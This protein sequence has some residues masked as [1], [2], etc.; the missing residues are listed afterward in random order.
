MLKRT[1]TFASFRFVS[2]ESIIKLAVSMQISFSSLLQRIR[3]HGHCVCCAGW[4]GVPVTFLVS[5]DWTFQLAV[6]ETRLGVTVS[7]PSLHQVQVPGQCSKNGASV[8][9]F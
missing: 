1:F 6:M 8:R 3:S 4:S 7:E 9:V 2:S 5:R